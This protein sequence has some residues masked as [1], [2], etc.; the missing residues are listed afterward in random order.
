MKKV[1]YNACYGG[2]GL[3]K[4]ACQ[5]YWEIKGQKVWIEDDEKYPSFGI[6]TV[7]L[8]PPEERIK[9]K[10]TEK[11]N[12]MSMNER[13]AYNEAYSAQTWYDRDIDRH[14]PVLVQVVEEL[15]DKAGGQFAKLRVTEVSGAYRITEY[16]GYESVET[17]DGCDWI[18]P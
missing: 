13:V 6:W 7:W 17:P 4:E 1:I 16:D 12:S 18:T 3:S 2:F 14:D 15:G 10:S 8:V 11:F 5:R 9:Q